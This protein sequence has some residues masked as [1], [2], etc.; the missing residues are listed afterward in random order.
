MK[1]TQSGDEAKATKSKAVKKEDETKKARKKR[2]S[3]LESD[4]NRK[5]FGF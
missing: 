1:T 2:E 4:R 3:S 5:N